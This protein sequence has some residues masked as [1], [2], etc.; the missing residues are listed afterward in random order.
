MYEAGIEVLGEK[1]DTISY[2]MYI[3]MESEKFK[4]LKFYAN[5]FCGER[6]GERG[7]YF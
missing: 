1:S 5:I 7:A 4:S 6:D 3:K 2:N